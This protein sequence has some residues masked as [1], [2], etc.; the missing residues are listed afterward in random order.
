M[1]VNTGESFVDAVVADRES[2]EI[3]AEEMEHGCVDIVDFGG[4]VTVC[5]FESPFIALAVSPPFY[6]CAT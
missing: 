2:F 5:G 6:T 1:A 4:V 3:D